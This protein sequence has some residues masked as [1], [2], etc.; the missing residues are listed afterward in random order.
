MTVRLSARIA[1]LAVLTA[2]ILAATAHVG[3]PSGLVALAIISAAE[4]AA[5]VWSTRAGSADA[6][7]VIAPAAL[8]GVT[9]AAVWTALVFVAPDVA[10]SDAPA[11]VAIATAGI[12]VAVRPPHETRRRR[13]VV[14]VAS[15]ST[16][17]LIFVA[18]SSVLPAFDGFVTNWRPPTHTDVT[19]LVDPILEFA[20][21]VML[22]LALLADFMWVRAR[23]R[24]TSVRERDESAPGEMVVLRPSE[25][26]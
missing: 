23:R 1:G 4:S 7:T 19:R 10:T 22:T 17:L 5:L 3:R 15:A 20:L 16:A 26:A 21:F 9:A 11:L 8:T 12:V 25:P 2:Q 18:I 13:Q 14:L 6:L 24:R